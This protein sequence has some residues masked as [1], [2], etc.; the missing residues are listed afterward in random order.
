[1]RL[2]EQCAFLRASK[3]AVALDD[4]FDVHGQIRG[5]ER[6]EETERQVLER[7]FRVQ[8]AVL[9]L[10]R[11]DAGTELSTC[12]AAAGHAEGAWVVLDVHGLAQRQRRN[13]G[14][15]QIELTHRARPAIGAG[16]SA[17]DAYLGAQ[18]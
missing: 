11:G 9:G 1:M 6:R 8:L 15:V 13:T 14:D 5:R 16:A 17:L 3:V 10:W 7:V 12:Q 18:G 4:R 2:A